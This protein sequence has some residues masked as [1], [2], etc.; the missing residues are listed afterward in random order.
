MYCVC[1]VQPLGINPLLRIPRTEF[2]DP[3]PKNRGPL[4]EDVN[5]AT[6][7]EIAHLETLTEAGCTGTPRLLGYQCMTQDDKMW[8]PGGYV[9]CIL[10]EFLPGISLE[11]FW[12]LPREERDQV[13]QAFQTAL[14]W[15]DTFPWEFPVTHLLGKYGDY[16]DWTL[17]IRYHKISYGTVKNRNGEIEVM[18]PNPTS[19]LN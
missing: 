19:V 12:W 18:C 5:E 4:S 11:N 3:D 13:R 10:M 17:S 2:P 16:P 1:T 7:L 6:V 9:F 15:V 14:E 8:L